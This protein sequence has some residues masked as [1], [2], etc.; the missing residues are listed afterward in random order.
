MN[1]DMHD[2]WDKAVIAELDA[3]L[4]LVQE[5]RRQTMED[6]TGKQVD[7][8]VMAKVFALGAVDSAIWRLLLRARGDQTW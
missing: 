4:A 3:V 6:A 7:P 1:D 8:V 5:R 2:L